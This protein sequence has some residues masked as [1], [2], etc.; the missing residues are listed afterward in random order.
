MIISTPTNGGRLVESYEGVFEPG[1][2]LGQGRLARELPKVIMRIA[3]PVSARRELGALIQVN[4]INNEQKR[5][6]ATLYLL[7][8]NNE[9]VDS[10]KVSLEPL[11]QTKQDILADSRLMKNDST[12]LRV[13]LD[14]GEFKL[15]KTISIKTDES[16]PVNSS[17]RL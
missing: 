14:A 10:M 13:L 12:V 2:E 15:G 7:D 5:V 9:E 4:L 8:E 6:F 17:T 16:L 3:A 1:G 11:S